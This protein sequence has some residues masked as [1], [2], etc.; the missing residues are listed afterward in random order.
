MDLLGPIVSLITGALEARALG[1]ALTA[2]EDWAWNF[3]K[4]MMSLFITSFVTFTATWGG[5]ALAMWQSTG[6]WIGLGV[7]FASGLAATGLI[8]YR[9]WTSNPLTKGITIAVP[10][11]VAKDAVNQSVTLTT[12]S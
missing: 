7:G 8:D 6:I 3:Y 10:S 4:L 9:L 2:A 11:Q 5:V 1:R 12:R